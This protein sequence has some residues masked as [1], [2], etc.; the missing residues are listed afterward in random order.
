[1][2]ELDKGHTAFGGTKSMGQLKAVFCPPA[3]KAT[4]HPL[5]SGPTPT[6]ST[7]GVNKNWEQDFM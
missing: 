4:F 5:H 3:S 2:K 6:L 7:T 1:M